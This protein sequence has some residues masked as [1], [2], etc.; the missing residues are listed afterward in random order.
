[1]ASTKIQTNSQINY[2]PYD[3]KIAKIILYQLVDSCGTLSIDNISIV[4]K[5][6]YILG[7]IDEEINVIIV[8]LIFSS[9]LPS[10]E[11]NA[12]DTYIYCAGI[13]LLAH[14]VLLDIP[15]DNK[16]WAK[17]SG[18]TL[19]KINKLELDLLHKFNYKL[20][21]NHDEFKEAYALFFNF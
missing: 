12:N 7:N 2:H 18:I 10:C 6:R 14:K 11:R 5:L 17:Y 21:V 4:N 9:R 3:N 8:A 1:M 13:I 16:I 19:K 20:S 15:H